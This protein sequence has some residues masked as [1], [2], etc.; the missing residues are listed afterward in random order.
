M[1][2]LWERVNDQNMSCFNNNAWHSHHPFRPIYLMISF[3][4]Q[5]WIQTRINRWISGTVESTHWIYSAAPPPV[6]LMG[7]MFLNRLLPNIKCIMLKIQVQWHG[8]TNT[9]VA[10]H[11]YKYQCKKTQTKQK[12][13]YKMEEMHGISCHQ[14]EMHHIAP[15]G[16]FRSRREFKAARLESGRDCTRQMVPIHY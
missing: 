12:H 7:W 1:T 16:A 4:S 5:K 15:P 14:P 8:Y 10:K 13:K 11:R 6:M 9:S 2:T 3:P